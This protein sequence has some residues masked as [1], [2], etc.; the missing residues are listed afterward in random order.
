MNVA[1]STF[2]T[3]VSKENKPH[4]G[5]CCLCSETPQL[6]PSALSSRSPQG[7]KRPYL[8]GRTKASETRR[9]NRSGSRYWS[10]LA[11]RKWLLPTVEKI[12]ACQSK[13]YLA[14]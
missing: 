5:Q 9:Q 6:V 8:K 7:G 2:P 10:G 4:P 12:A 14:A 13:F 3:T 11:L 1:Q